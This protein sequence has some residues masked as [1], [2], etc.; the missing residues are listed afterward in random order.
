MD[1][2]KKGTHLVKFPPIA[3]ILD[4]HF[5]RDRDAIVQWIHTPNLAFKGRTPNEMLE[6]RQVMTVLR[7]CQLHLEDRV[8]ARVRTNLRDS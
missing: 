8:Y 7:F 4:A 6:D 2:T 5:R 3:Q 1:D